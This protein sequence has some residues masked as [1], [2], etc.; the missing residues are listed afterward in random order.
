MELL[1]RPRVFDLDALITLGKPP[2]DP[3]ESP[4]FRLIEKLLS[5]K[6]LFEYKVST[7]AIL[8]VEACFQLDEAPGSN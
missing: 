4:L 1:A 8:E 6:E 7:P 3:D 2:C 5:E